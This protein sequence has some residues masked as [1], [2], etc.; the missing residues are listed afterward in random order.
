MNSHNSKTEWVVSDE[1]VRIEADQKQVRVIKSNLV[2]ESELAIEDDVDIGGDPY[3][4]TGQHVIIKP[5]V[6]LED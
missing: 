6:D 1:A 5:K 4:S 3:N 2:D